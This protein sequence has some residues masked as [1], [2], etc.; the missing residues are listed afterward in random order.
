MR[1]QKLRVGWNHK[2]HRFDYQSKKDAINDC[3]N[4]PQEMNKN[5]KTSWKIMSPVILRQQRQ[6]H[7]MLSCC[8]HSTSQ[9]SKQLSTAT[10]PLKFPQ[11]K[12]IEWK[13]FKNLSSSTHLSFSNIVAH[14]Y[15]TT[16]SVTGNLWRVLWVKKELFSLIN[17]LSGFVR[18]D[19]NNK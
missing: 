18:N 6:V 11:S 14:C 8:R 16:I 9:P 10:S 4:F 12:Q 7:M 3:R 17:N 19:R 15:Q 1:R 5:D 2:N 13:F